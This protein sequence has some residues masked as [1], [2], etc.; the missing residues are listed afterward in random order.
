MSCVYTTGDL[1]D[2]LGATVLG[3]ATPAIRMHR[4]K[5]RQDTG[6]MEKVVHQRVDGDH[7][8]AGFVPRDSGVLGS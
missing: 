2:D 3:V 8:A 6:A 7:A 4:V 1:F 5:L